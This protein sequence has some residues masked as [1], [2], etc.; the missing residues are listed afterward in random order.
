MNS[1]VHQI[2]RE[3]FFPRTDVHQEVE[4]SNIPGRQEQKD[5]TPAAYVCQKDQ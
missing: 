3:E 5:V 1:G 2:S 4:N